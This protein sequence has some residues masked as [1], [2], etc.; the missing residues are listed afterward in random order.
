VTQP[1]AFN[2]FITMILS[3]KNIGVFICIG[4]SEDVIGQL[5]ERERER[6]RAAD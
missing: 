6:K 2:Q 4:T 5:E 1:L 3:H